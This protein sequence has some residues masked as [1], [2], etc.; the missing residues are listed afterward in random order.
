MRITAL[1]FIFLTLVVFQVGCTKKP[2]TNTETNV[3]VGPVKESPFA[4]ITDPN[5]AL[6]EGNRLLDDNQTEL[7]IEAYKQAISLNA[8]LAEAHF[9]LG[10]AYALIEAEMQ[11]NGVDINAGTNTDGKKN[12]PVK[13]NSQKEFEKAVTAY[14]KLLAASPKDD[15]A[16]F[17]LGRAYNKLNLDDEAEDAFRAAVKLKPGDTEYQTELGAILIKLA[18]YHEALPVL[19]K[20]LEIDAENSRAEKLLEDAEAGAKRID[21]SSPDKGNRPANSNANMSSNS[22]SGSNSAVT[23]SGGKPTNGDTRPRKVEPGDKKP[24]GPGGKASDKRP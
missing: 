17:N 22:N 4:N 7:A 23:N 13:T 3:E 15:T 8:D 24:N 12:S 10:I 16:Q 18:K 14:K 20:A 9:K 21:Y 6:A 19:K 1:T 2:E 5:A 11:Q